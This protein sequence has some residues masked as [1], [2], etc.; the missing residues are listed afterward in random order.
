MWE[1]AGWHVSISMPPA[2][3]EKC[4]LTSPFLRA[5]PLW[6]EPA[7]RREIVDSWTPN[8]TAISA[9]VQPI[10]ASLT[11]C[12]VSIASVLLWASNIGRSATIVYDSVPTSAATFSAW[13]LSTEDSSCPAC[14]IRA[15]PL[16]ARTSEHRGSPV[17]R[18]LASGARSRARLSAP[19]C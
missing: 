1:G 12:T 3:G 8:C 18:P 4:L 19:A 14:L 5:R 9:F 10:A 16:A 2:E 15:S 11:N 17:R 7:K 6:R 13:R